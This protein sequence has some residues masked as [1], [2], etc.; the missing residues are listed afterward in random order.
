MGA[1]RTVPTFTTAMLASW[2]LFATVPFWIERVG[3]YQYLAVE[4]LIWAT[5]ALAFNLASPRSAT[6]P[7]SA[8]APTRSAWRSSISHRTCGSASASP[9]SP[10]QRAAPS[11]RS[12]SRTGAPSTTL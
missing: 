3:L 10:P 6:A 4:I 11:T 8:S 5:Y 1:G 12:S 2:L 7:S 9:R